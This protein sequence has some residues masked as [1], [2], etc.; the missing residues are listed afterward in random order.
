MC[1][2]TWA[3]GLPRSLTDASSFPTDRGGLPPSPFPCGLRRR[4]HPLVGFAL[5]QSP[6]SSR[7]PERSRARAP[8]LGS[9]PS[10]RPEHVESTSCR[11]SHPG[12]VPPAAFRTLSTACSS[13]CLA[14][15]FHRAAMSRVLAPGVSSSDLAAP[16]RRWPLPSRRWRP[17]PAGCP[18]PAKVASTSG[19]C[20]QTGIR[21][22]PRAL[23]S[24]RDTRVPSCVFSSLGR[25]S[26]DLGSA[27][28]LPP[29]AALSVRCY[30]CPAPVTLSVS[31]DLQPSPLSP[32]A[33]PVRASLAFESVA[34]LA[35]PISSER[36]IATA[37]THPY[38]HP[39]CQPAA[40]GNHADLRRCEIGGD[41][42]ADDGDLDNLMAAC[43]PGGGSGP[44]PRG[45]RRAV[46]VVH[47]RRGDRDQD[48][49]HTARA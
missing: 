48:R 12:Y 39:A 20:L 31:I 11:G 17:S 6:S 8:P 35:R 14:R 45:Y 10:S 26:R 43:G 4:V 7:P 47:S 15:L 25:F 37:D 2:C 21:S 30:V 19:S 42:G 46:V 32:E 40:R 23:S 18:A 49:G 27:I 28:A 3:V 1:R 9:R 41:V 38:E 22:A 29:L 24:P 34:L 5:L 16:P 33:L 13:S 44:A 36:L